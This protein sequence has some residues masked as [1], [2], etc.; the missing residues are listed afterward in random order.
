MDENKT[1]ND[2]DSKNKHVSELFIIALL[3]TLVDLKVALGNFLVYLQT[4]EV[5]A[6]LM[7]HVDDKRKD[8]IQAL[9]NELI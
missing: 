1:T 8:K 5:R 3:A 2:S 6:F 7:D 9:I 4:P